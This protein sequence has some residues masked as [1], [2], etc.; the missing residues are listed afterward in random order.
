MDTEEAEWKAQSC[1]FS[2]MKSAL[3]WAGIYLLNLLAATL[4]VF[5]ATGF[6]L[7]VVLKP[8]APLIGHSQLFSVARGP[9]YP[10]SLGIAVLTGY[11]SYVRFKGNQR[12]WVWVLPA[13]YLAIKIILWKSPSV[14]GSTSLGSA[15]THFFPGK[16]PYPEEDVTVPLYT[17]VAYAF[18]ALL[19]RSGLFRL[20]HSDET[21]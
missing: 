10:L 3:R 13:V 18:G 16:A 1:I 4:G 9:L 17:S 6:L 14:F 5:V 8:M 2:A 21:P 15:M 7:N 12:F 11:I 20:Q 19:E